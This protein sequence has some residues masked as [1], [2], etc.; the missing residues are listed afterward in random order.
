M[1]IIAAFRVEDG[2][3]SAQNKVVGDALRNLWH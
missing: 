3:R 1:A 2:V